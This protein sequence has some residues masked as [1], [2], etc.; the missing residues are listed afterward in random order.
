M[1]RRGGVDV[2]GVGGMMRPYVVCV[3]ETERCSIKVFTASMLTGLQ[4]K[5]TC[6]HTQ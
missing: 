5:Y 6:T 3:Y 4:M 2:C 1:W